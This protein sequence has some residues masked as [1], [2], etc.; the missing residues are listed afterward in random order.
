MTMRAVVAAVFLL[1]CA[2][3]A[4]AQTP[5]DPVG[6]VRAIY[7]AY[8]HDNTPAWYEQN[9]SARLRKMIDADRADADKDD[10]AGKFDWDPIINA[11]DWKLAD[12]RVSLVSR[13]GDGAVVDASFRNLGA[14]QRMRFSLALEGGKWAI[15]DVQ[16]L[17]KPRWTMSKVYQGAPDAF[18]D[19]AKK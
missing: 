12:L 9:Y 4:T 15:D 18:P 1:V 13:A 10:D 2:A 3:A 16:S 5:T 19:E 7:A 8:Q 11:Q 14:D 6:F 17:N